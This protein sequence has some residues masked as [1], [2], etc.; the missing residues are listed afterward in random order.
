MNVLKSMGIEVLLDLFLM[1]V[2]NVPG[3]VFGYHLN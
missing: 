1:S 3:Y 2:N